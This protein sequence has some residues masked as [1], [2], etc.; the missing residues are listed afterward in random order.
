LRAII[1]ENINDKGNALHCVVQGVLSLAKA[2]DEF[3]EYG[4][5][6]VCKF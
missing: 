1:Q 6:D 2:K 4:N 3:T 5:I